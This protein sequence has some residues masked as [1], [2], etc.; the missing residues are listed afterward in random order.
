MNGLCHES[1]PVN[2]RKVKHEGSAHRQHVVRSDT[3]RGG[4]AGIY[5]V[6]SEGNAHLWERK[7]RYEPRALARSRA[8]A[9]LGVRR[10]AA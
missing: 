8:F 10:E 1:C 6:D 5:I 2:S 4:W 3:F 9:A 7:S